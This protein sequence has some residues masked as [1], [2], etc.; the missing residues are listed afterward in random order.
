MSSIDEIRDARIKKLELLKSKSINPYPT[1]SSR[2][3]SLKEAIENFNKTGQFSRPYLGV[4]YRMIDLKTALNNDVVQ[5]AY[6]QEV[7]E[8]SPAARGGIEPGDI[9]TKMGGEKIDGDDQNGLAKLISGHKVGDRVELEVW[10]EGETNKL[11]VTLE[12]AK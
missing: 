12:E 4:R 2:E 1:S 5:G 3:I 8:D 11:T 10:R 6:V 7:I 9:I